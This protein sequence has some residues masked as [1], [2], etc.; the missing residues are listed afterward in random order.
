MSAC[1]SLKTSRGIQNKC[2]LIA[3]L[4]GKE[5]AII[6]GT[7]L[8][9]NTLTNSGIFWNEKAD[10]LAKQVTDSTPFIDWIASEDIISNFKKQSIQITHEN[11]RKR[12]Y[13]ALI[14]NVPDILTISKWTGNRVQDRPIARI[15]SKT[16]VTPGLLHRFNLHPDPLCIIC[17]EI[18]DISHILL[19]CKNMHLSELFPGTN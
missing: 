12:K 8:F 11:Y 7:N 13:Q 6:R 16:T 15:I 10:S 18:N 9:S 17:N 19:K 4:G 14:G 1:H 2:S 3:V 5:L